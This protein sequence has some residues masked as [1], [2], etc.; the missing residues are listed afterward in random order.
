MSTAN[1]AQS[2]GSCSGTATGTIQVHHASVT[3]VS[4]GGTG[5]LES[6]QL[7][8]TITWDTTDITIEENLVFAGQVALVGSLSKH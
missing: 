1:G 3:C 7:T 6:V 2:F 4:S 5:R 8:F